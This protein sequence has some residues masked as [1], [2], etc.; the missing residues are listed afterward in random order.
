MN[1]EHNEEAA[2]ECQFDVRWA[3]L[4]ANR[5]VRNTIFSDFATHTR[6]QL[7][8]TLGFSQSR[9]EALRFGPVV[10]KEEIRYRREVVFGDKLRVNVCCSGL[11]MD[12]SQWRVRQDVR[13]ADGKEAVV[14]AIQ[15]GWIDLDQ[16]KAIVPP[17][18]LSALMREIP[19]TPNFTVLPSLIRLGKTG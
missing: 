3:D 7:L 11:A 13:R 6:F 15:G 18:M 17:A 12:C 16:R 9:F 5:H 19:R 1:E 10:L 4:D 8:E 14:L 2:F